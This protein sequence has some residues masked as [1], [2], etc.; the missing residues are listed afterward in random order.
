MVRLVEEMLKHLWVVVVYF[1]VMVCRSELS[2]SFHSAAWGSG[3]VV[4]C[5][6]HCTA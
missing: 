3:S 4:Y 2:T 6:C 1:V 5:H